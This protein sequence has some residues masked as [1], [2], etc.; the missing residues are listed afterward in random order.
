MKLKHEAMKFNENQ[1]IDRGAMKPP[2]K[3]KLNKGIALLSTTDNL[4]IF[5]ESFLLGVKH[6]KE[7]S[8]IDRT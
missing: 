1:L 2:I 4:L 5:R 3:S 7:V 6:S 8:L